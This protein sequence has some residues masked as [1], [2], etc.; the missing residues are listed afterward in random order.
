MQRGVY[1][2][3]IRIRLTPYVHT[4]HKL[5]CHK[6]PKKLFPSLLKLPTNRYFIYS[7]T[8]GRTFLYWHRK[9]DS[10]RRSFFYM[11]NTKKTFCHRKACF[12]GY[13]E[14]RKRISTNL[15]PELSVLLRLVFWSRVLCTVYG[16]AASVIHILAFKNYFVSVFNNKF[17]IFNKINDF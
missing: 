3:N 14:K 6:F 16:S 12:I 8:Y 17:L 15:I 11:G 2:D 10:T 5:H 1:T 9:L 4:C 13:M 7:Q